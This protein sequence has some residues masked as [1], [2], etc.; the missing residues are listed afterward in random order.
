MNQ[1]AKKQELIHQ[2]VTEGSWNPQERNRQQDERRIRRNGTGSRMKEESAGTEQEAGMK[3][4]S[5]V[6]KWRVVQL[7]KISELL[8][9]SLKRAPQGRLVVKRQKAHAERVLL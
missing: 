7:E 8:E 9:S 3:L 4:F 1:K 2:N 5:T 6:V